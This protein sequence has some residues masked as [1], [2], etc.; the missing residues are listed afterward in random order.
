MKQKISTAILNSNQPLNRQ[1]IRIDDPN[2]RLHVYWIFLR[3]GHSE[4][5][6]SERNK[7]SFYELQ[8]MQE[9]FIRQTA[10]TGG[11]VQQYTVEAG[12]FM[13]VPPNRYH[14]VVEASETGS[15]F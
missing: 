9:G 6:L 12:Q 11:T 8:L 10:E 3:S 15:A 4:I 14:Q 1:I 2:M 7:H 13:I 5:L